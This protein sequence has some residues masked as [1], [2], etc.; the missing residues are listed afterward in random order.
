MLSRVPVFP[1]PELIF[2]C[3][4]FSKHH[5]DDTLKGEWEGR[6]LKKIKTQTRER[7]GRRVHLSWK[8]SSVSGFPRCASQSGSTA[9]PRAAWQEGRQP[10]F[11]GHKALSRAALLTG[12]HES[13]CRRC[14]TS[15]Q[16]LTPLLRGP[17]QDGLV[18]KEADGRGTS[19]DVTERVSC[20]AC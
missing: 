18:W 15:T 9:G 6:R 20:P 4:V 11:L 5:H 12:V 7:K 3:F 1:V 14:I 2:S 10:R 16:V 13:R 17:S 8:S 19:A